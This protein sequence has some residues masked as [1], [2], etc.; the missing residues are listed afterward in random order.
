MVFFAMPWAGRLLWH[1]NRLQIDHHLI[2]ITRPSALHYA[3]DS[4]RQFPLLLNVF[5]D[6]FHRLVRLI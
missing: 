5:F 4:A 2:L 6:T 3:G 1:E